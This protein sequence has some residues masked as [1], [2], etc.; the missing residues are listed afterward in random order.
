MRFINHCRGN[1]SAAVDIRVS[2]VITVHN[3]EKHIAQC[4]DSVIG[5]TLREIEIICVDDASTDG[6]Y[7][8]LRQYAARDCR[9]RLFRFDRNGG[10]QRARNHAIGLA[11]GEFITF[12]DDDDWLGEDCLANCMECQER[13]HEA[14][15]ILIPEMRQ[16]PDGSLYEPAGRVDFDTVTGEEAFILSMPWRIAGNFF[17]RTA[18]QRRYPFDESC[19]YFGDENTGRLL[20]LT[21]R[22]VA[23]SKGMYYY[24]MNETSV[25]HSTGIGHYSRLDAQRVLADTLHGMGVEESLLR[26]YEEFCWLNVVGVYMRYYKERRQMDN[27]MRREA[28]AIIRRA[29]GRMRFNLLG[30]SIKRHFGYIPFRNSWS[31]FRVQEELYFLLR[32]VMGRMIMDDTGDPDRVG[33]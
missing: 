19:R 9:I 18:L 27:A 32:S 22:C 7:D 20:L 11:R 24:R 16:R 23:M 6:S 29:H 4:L 2:V 33:K 17:V 26:A 30:K 1:V 8:I 5:Q 21:S 3:R 14:D 25:C 28:L 31:L 15:C 10:V 13:H 12:V